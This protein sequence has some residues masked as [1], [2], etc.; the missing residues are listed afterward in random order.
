MGM[1]KKQY[2]KAVLLEEV[3]KVLQENLQKYLSEE[4]LNVLGNPLPKNDNE[5][6]WEGEDFTFEF[7][8][9][10]SP[11]FNVD[12]TKKAVTQYKVVA[13]A[14]MLDNQVK[15]IRKQRRL[16]VLKWVI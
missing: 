2:G 9:G 14:K 5:I 1:V 3:N 4:K 16:L 7:D 12:V 15:T 8:L 11:V 13:D 6:D 10:L